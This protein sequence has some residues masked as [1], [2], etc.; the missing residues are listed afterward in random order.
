MADL[1]SLYQSDVIQEIPEPPPLYSTGI[2]ALDRSLG[3]GVPAGS[4][5]YILADPESM[6]EIFLYQFTQPRKTCLLYTSPSPR[7]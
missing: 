3:G 7:D 5:I 2:A 6:S 1:M 4:V